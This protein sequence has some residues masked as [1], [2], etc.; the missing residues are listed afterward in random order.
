MFLASCLPPK[1]IHRSSSLARTWQE[2]A[3]LVFYL[4]QGGL[5]YL[6]FPHRTLPGVKGSWENGK[7]VKV[8]FWVIWLLLSHEAMGSPQQEPLHISVGPK[9]LS[10]L[11][12]WM[13]VSYIIKVESSKSWRIK[14]RAMPAK[15][16]SFS[17][18]YSEMALRRCLIIIPTFS[19]SS[20][21]VVLST[22]GSSARCPP[23]N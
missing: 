19:V 20:P 5:F 1:Y 14:I 4:N 9:L 12:G 21:L 13:A 10:D 6:S 11:L 17:Q 22:A 2:I 3:N 15:V 7:K 16:P 18:Y 23:I 8:V